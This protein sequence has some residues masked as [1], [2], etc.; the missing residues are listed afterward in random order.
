MMLKLKDAT[1]Q[2]NNTTSQLGDAKEQLRLHS[3]QNNNTAVNADI[4]SLFQQYEMWD[5]LRCGSYDTIDDAMTTIIQIKTLIVV[6][7]IKR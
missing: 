4:I 2:L 7:M 3:N 6:I 1:S 5:V